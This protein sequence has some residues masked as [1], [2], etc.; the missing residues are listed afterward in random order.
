ML[1]R[2]STDPIDLVAPVNVSRDVAIGR[3]IL[4]WDR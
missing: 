4:A 2:R 1:E 3:K